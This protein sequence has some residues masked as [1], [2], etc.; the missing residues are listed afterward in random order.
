[1]RDIA[2]LVCGEVLPFHEFLQQS[3]HRGSMVQTAATAYKLSNNV[4]V[5]VRNA[6]RVKGSSR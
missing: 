1:M 2:H 6:Q 5:S 4:V 3:L